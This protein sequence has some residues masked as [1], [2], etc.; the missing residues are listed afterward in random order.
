MGLESFDRLSEEKQESNAELMKIWG[1]AGGKLGND[2][3]ARGNNKILWKSFD[4]GTLKVELMPVTKEGIAGTSM[5]DG[6]GKVITET[7]DVKANDFKFNV[8]LSNLNSSSRETIEMKF[9]ID[10]SVDVVR[11]EPTGNYI[12]AIPHLEY[13]SQYFASDDENGN[14]CVSCFMDDGFP[15]FEKQK[16]GKYMLTLQFEVPDGKTCIFYD[17]VLKYVLIGV[18]AA[19]SVVAADGSGWFRKATVNKIPKYTR[20]IF[21]LVWNGQHRRECIELFKNLLAAGEKSDIAEIKAKTAKANAEIEQAHLLTFEAIAEM[22]K[23]QEKKD[24]IIKESGKSRQEFA[25][26]DFIVREYWNENLADN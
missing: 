5:T 10:G 19:S 6:D 4:G 23:C 16:S 12:W 17:P 18:L 11:H 7:F 26:Y 14:G 24:E 2:T 21:S 9:E 15:K 8:E 25:K 1:G 22:F 13:S 20:R 3:V